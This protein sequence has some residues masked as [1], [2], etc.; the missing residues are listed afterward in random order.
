MYTNGKVRAHNLD[1][2]SSVDNGSLVTDMSVFS[3]FQTAWASRFPG[4][5]LPKAWEEDVRGNLAK[6][7]QKVAQLKEELE[8]EE[9][10]VEYLER[11]LADVE[12]VRGEKQHQSTTTTS[13]ASLVQSASPVNDQPPVSKDASG[14]QYVTVI[15]VSSYGEINKKGGNYTATR[16][17]TTNNDDTE[18]IDNP[19][20][21]DIDNVC[22][23]SKKNR[24]RVSQ[25]QI[26][27][28]HVILITFSKLS[29]LPCLCVF[30]A[31]SFLLVLFQ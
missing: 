21:Q 27:Q 13:T 15:T 6:H 28:F 3:D 5:E 24:D 4:C 14:D 25:A 19:L 26:L 7:K 2:P 10:Y 20:Y 17:Q 9:F 30:R 23:E 8:K 16:D 31:L 11:L 18:L 12:R 1:M 22:N 29:H